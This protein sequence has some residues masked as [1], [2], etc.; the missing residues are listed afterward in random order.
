MRIEYHANAVA[1][2]CKIMQPIAAISDASE[3]VVTVS[4]IKTKQPSLSCRFTPPGVVGKAAQDCDGT[5]LPRH[6]SSPQWTLTYAS[7]RSA[8]MRIM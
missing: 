3:I 2:V 1:V 8:V 4:G 6:C 7:C 5:A